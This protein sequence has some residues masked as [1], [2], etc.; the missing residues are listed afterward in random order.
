MNRKEIA[1]ETLNIQQQGYY[2]LDGR[3]ID[4]GA[5]QRHSENASL[6]LTPEEGAKLVREFVPPQNGEAAS[7]RVV[8][9]STVQAIVDM[10]R[11][12]KRPAVLNF[13]SA[14]N[15]G[16]GFL[17]GAM[18]QEEALAAS[19]GLYCTQLLHEIYYTANRACGTMM[20]TDHAI[21]SPDVVFFRDGGFRL[22]NEPVT[23][24]VLTLPAV[25]MGQVILKGENV[26][27]AKIAMKN[28]MRLCLAIFAA[29]KERHLILGA[30]GCGVFRN[31][32]EEVVVWWKE[33]LETEGYIRC[34]DKIVFAILERSG[35]NMQPFV[36][37]FG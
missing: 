8:N 23:A 4:I 34:F 12:G 5:L 11:E 28:R 17:N 20:Y 22:L 27:Q 21:Y 13:A 10:G 6:L 9:Q 18:A 35:K 15:P 2:E 37:L 1:Q 30:Y 31:D 16:G 19:S 26:E 36:R 25:N 14:K 33:L 24:S 3:R 32:P 7:Y 29:H